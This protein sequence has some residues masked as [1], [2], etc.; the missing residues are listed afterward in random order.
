MKGAQ[1]TQNWPKLQT[2]ILLSQGDTY[3]LWDDNYLL[4]GHSYLFEDDN[5]LLPG[6][7][8]FFEDDNY[9]SQAIT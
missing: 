7:S 1:F 2:R 8:Y 5:Y 3:F 4:P 9:F 6:H